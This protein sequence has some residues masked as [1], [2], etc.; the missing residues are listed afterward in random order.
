M[1]FRAKLAQAAAA[2]H[3]LLCVGL[4]P[5]PE[6][7]PEDE[8]AGYLCAV[9]D[10]TKDLV[11]AFKPNLAFYEQ[12]GVRGHEVLRTVLE[13]IPADIPTIADAK[14]GDIGHTMEAYARALFDDLGFDAA[15]VN[16]YLGRD[17]LQPFLDRT[18]KGAF[19]LCR[20]SNPGARDLQDLLV[21]DVG[22]QRPLYVVVAH[23]AAAWDEHSNVGLVAGA[24]YPEELKRL[25][26]ICPEMPFLVPGVGSQEGSLEEAVRAGL[27]AKGGGIVVNA[28]RSVLYASAGTDYAE[29]ARRE[30]ARLREAIETQRG[31]AS[32]S[33]G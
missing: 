1:S 6:R 24:T 8:L 29:A 2:N 27:D 30:A 16:P 4:D 32:P 18:D 17:G 13:A 31:A 33:R 22:A 12:L 25:R 26:A 19:I 14:R 9:V 3:S 5:D 20:T 21:D 23:K 11:C 28:S 15:T 10:A 7:I